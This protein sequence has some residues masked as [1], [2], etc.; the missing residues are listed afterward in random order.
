[1]YSNTMSQQTTFDHCQAVLNHKWNYPS[2]TMRA[3]QPFH[4][5]VWTQNNNKLDHCSA[6]CCL[7]FPYS[8]PLPPHA[9]P[10]SPICFS[11]PPNKTRKMTTKSK[12][13][14]QNRA[15]QRAFRLRKERYVKDL[16][17]KAQLLDEWRVEIELLRQE[18]QQ[19]RE[20]NQRLE[21]EQKQP[22]K[23]STLSKMPPP[24]VTLV[25]PLQCKKRKLSLSLSG[26]PNQDN[27]PLQSPTAVLPPY[28]SS[29]S[30][31]LSNSTSPISPSDQDN[32]AFLLTSSYT[33]PYTNE[34]AYL[35]TF[36]LAP[37]SPFEGSTG[38]PNLNM[39]D[40]FPGNK[41]YSQGDNGYQSS[42]NVSHDNYVCRN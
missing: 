28:S 13:A 7:S 2:S 36:P 4:H 25:D 1:M 22:M 18:N 38:Y 32:T 9:P 31:P 37:C 19:L 24:I 40:M 5:N 42:L 15:A 30:S 16:E 3:N 33:S 34:Q 41:V 6:Y 8:S 35:H 26:A 29:V 39:Y 10:P 27:E 17:R 11:S 21:Q 12:R 20:V 14:E 23:K